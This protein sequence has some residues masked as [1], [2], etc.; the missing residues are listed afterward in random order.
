MLVV[1]VVILVAVGVV[2]VVVMVVVVVHYG[3]IWPSMDSN[4]HKQPLTTSH[5]YRSSGGGGGDR[6]R[7]VESRLKV[8]WESVK[9]RLR[10]S[11]ESV[12]SQ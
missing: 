9:S 8:G 2:R 11:W 12:E 4:A 1:V 6:G 3:S 10:V 5:T 7:S